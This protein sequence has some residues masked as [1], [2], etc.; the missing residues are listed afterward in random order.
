MK[1]YIYIYDAGKPE[2]K[3]VMKV[4]LSKHPNQFNPDEEAFVEYSLM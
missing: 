2:G 3:T 4:L 1:L